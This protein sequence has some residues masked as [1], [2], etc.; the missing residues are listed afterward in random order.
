M[1]LRVFNTYVAKYFQYECNNKTH[2]SSRVLGTTRYD[3]VQYRNEVTGRLQIQRRK[4]F[5][6]LFLND[7]S[8]KVLTK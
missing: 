6:S 4:K 7:R 5:A 3:T 8:K 2:S 1:S